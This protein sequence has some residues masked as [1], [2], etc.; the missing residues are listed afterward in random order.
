MAKKP[1]SFLRELIKD[2]GDV[3]THLADEGMHSS[4]FSGFIDTGSYAFNALLSG[5]LFG[6]VP[7]NKITAIAGESAT[8]KTFFALGMVRK[9]LEDHAE[10][11][12]IYYDTEA[13]VTKQM[14]LDRGIDTKRVIISEQ[15]T[16]QSFR[17]HVMRTLERLLEIP[18]SERPPMMMVL[19]SFG[20][21]S[22]EKEVG[23]IKEGKDTRDM[24]R[25]QLIRGTFRAISLRMAKANVPMIITNHT[26]DVVGAYVPTKKMSG[27]GG[28]QYAAS[29]IIFLSKKKDRDGDKEV[30]GNIITCKTDKSRF[31]KENKRIDVRLSYD[32]GLDRYYGLLDLAE[33][34]GVVTKVANKYEFPNGEKAF[35]KK[36]YEQPERYFTDEVMHKLEEFA[37]KE[38]RYG[39]GEEPSDDT[40]ETEE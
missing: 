40:V 28:L 2:I 17:T 13:A 37:A 25:A 14:M 21:L 33:K 22:T 6:G 29:Q 10:A 35:E 20:M 4:E 18:Q 32:T 31:T 3:D 7:N 16:V 1:N 36:V 11:G 26:Y 24:T 23:D 9:F 27:G 12:V 34:Y 30:I 39:K 19:D 38:F 8:G 15:T 5:S